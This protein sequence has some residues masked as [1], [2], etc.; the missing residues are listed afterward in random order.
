MEKNVKKMKKITLY[1]LGF[2]I[3]HISAANANKQNSPIDNPNKQKYFLLDLDAKSNLEYKLA[4]VELNASKL[5]EVDK[6]IELFNLLTKNGNLILF[7]VLPGKISDNIW[8]EIDPASLKDKIMDWDQLK[9]FR[10][11]AT[12]AYGS[13][14][15]GLYEHVKRNDINLV[16]KENGKYFR[17]SSCITEFFSV[18]NKP[19]MFTSQ[20]DIA[21][22]NIYSPAV[23]L[24]DFDSRYKELYNE[25][26]PNYHDLPN[27]LKFPMNKPLLFLSGTSTIDGRKAYHFWGFM[28]WGIS[29][30]P[31]YRRGIDRFI[32]I[33][34]LGIVGGSFDF[35]FDNLLDKSRKKE[36]YL[37]ENVM[38]PI[39]ING[40]EVS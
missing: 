18:E 2:F 39:K 3:V 11:E 31:N 7:S 33:P 9:A 27:V 32:F 40:K 36:N 22:I 21:S 38:Q 10:I 12:R 5:Y 23:A 13:S 30:S 37:N 34:E 15:K 1:F 24:K 8:K 20:N 29:D 35:F 17:S 14:C 6:K 25:P 26:S 28:D 19:R 16:K 4:H